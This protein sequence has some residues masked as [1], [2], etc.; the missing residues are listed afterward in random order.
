MKGLG[1]GGGVDGLL[2]I[3]Q[4]RI[5]GIERRCCVGLDDVIWGKGNLEVL[6]KHLVEAMDDV[7]HGL[8]LFIE[9][10]EKTVVIVFEEGRFAIG[11]LPSL[12]VVFD[13]VL[14][15][16]DAHFGQGPVAI[17]MVHGDGEGLDVVGCCDVVSIGSVLFDEGGVEQNGELL[18]LAADDK[19]LEG[20][21]Y[22]IGE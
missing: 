13:P 16:V 10:G 5:L 14:V 17:F 19:P 18:L 6:E 20:W 7:L 2:V 8:G 3:G 21:Q 1:I 9:H 22:D 15:V 12:F 11:G 4:Q